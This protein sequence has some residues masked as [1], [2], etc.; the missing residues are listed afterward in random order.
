M[1]AVGVCCPA[2]GAS[3]L[4]DENG[5]FISGPKKLS[6][7]RDGS[8][9]YACA[10]KPGEVFVV[11]PPWNMGRNAAGYG[12]GSVVVYSHHHHHETHIFLHGLGG[13]KRAGLAQDDGNSAR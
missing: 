11:K 2:C 8:V 6:T 9:R 7:S 5:K 1:A 4:V 12:G 13:G 3:R 10:C